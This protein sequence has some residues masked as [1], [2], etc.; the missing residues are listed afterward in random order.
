MLVLLVAVLALGIGAKS[1][2]QSL[3]VP[4]LPAIG[5]QLG[6]SANAAGW[7]LTANLLAAAVATPVLGRLGDTWGERSVALGV[8]AA[9][10]AGTLL[11][12][13]TSSLPLL[14]VARVL[15]GA[16]YGLFPLA[17]SVLRRELPRERLT[18]AMAITASALGVGSGLALVATGLLTRDDADYRRIFWLCVAMTV[19]VIG[20]MLAAVPNRAGSGGRVDYAGALVLGIGLVCLLLPTSQGHDWGWGSARV[21]G[22]YVAA[23]VVLVGFWV[24]QS[25]RATPLVSVDLLKHRAVLATNTASLCVGF[26][27]FSVF[28]GA[29]YFVQT[30]ELLAGYGFGASVLRTSVV[31][32]LPAAIVSILVGPIAG[33]LVARRGPR[34]V[35][36]GA[37][38]VGVVGMMMLTV[39]HDNTGEMIGG[40]IVANVAVAAAYA[41][42]P[43]LL[44]ANVEPQETGIANSINSIMR[45]V[46][47]AVGS[48][49]IITVLAAEVAVHSVHGVP[50]ALPTENA[51]RVAFLLGAG[52]FALAAALAAFAIPRGGH[53]M[54]AHQREEEIAVGAAGEFSTASVSLD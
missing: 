23:V 13:V 15:Q 25:R 47:G 36:L 14:L 28:L 53:P 41:A 26:A 31:F 22:L 4:L 21:I 10:S 33:L 51:Y 20:L 48:A 16:S 2:M 34:V 40:L 8:L 35:L 50:V 38:L 1:L 46:G 24:L 30:P 6:V 29:T 45:T 54:S 43:A 32:M 12:L 3:V 7:V 44:V 27:M 17:I 52:A 37:A 39:L 5:E 18:A 42:M 19:V 11:A 49:V 9:M